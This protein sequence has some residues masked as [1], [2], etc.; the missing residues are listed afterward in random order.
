MTV[1]SRRAFVRGLAGF[2]ASAAGLALVGGC[3]LVPLQAPPKRPR[4]GYLSPGPREAMTD[5]VDPFLDGLRALGY[6]EG[7][8]IAVEWR[9]A[10]SDDDAQFAELAAELVRMPV[11]LIA[12]RTGAAV[13]AVTGASSAMPVVML[14]QA[15]PVE[16]GLVA[17]LAR[18]GA[19]VT[20]T[21]STVPGIHGKRLE[22]LQ[23]VVPG[24]TRVAA[25][26]WASSPSEEVNWRNL[27]VAA[28]QAG[29]HLERIELRSVDDLDAAFDMSRQVRA[30]ALFDIQNPLLLPVRDR[31]A[32]LALQHH[33]PGM[34]SGRPYVASGLLMSY[35][36]NFAALQ[37][38]AAS[39]VDRILKG[40]TPA[41]LPVAQATT[42]EFF[43]NVNTA[44]ALGLTIPPDV[45]AQVTEWVE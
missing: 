7:D 3:G 33:L 26:M 30:D 23:E 34:L 14:G 21:T 35:V 31:F 44:Q 8:T 11:A 12:A 22:L 25:F 19:N 37:R 42:F 4:I 2:G 9:F 15:N 38:Q 6:V 5:F 29:V 27:S 32:G 24:L 39:Y 10:P 18:P 1:L 43:V 45:A 16:T 40:A 41:D 17:T 28:G 20:G 36:T 13:R